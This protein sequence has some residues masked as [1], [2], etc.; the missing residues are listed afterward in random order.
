[1]ADVTLKCQ[2]PEPPLAIK[3]SHNLRKFLSLASIV[4]KVQRCPTAQQ[5]EDHKME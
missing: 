4:K 1:V 5:V 2:I 3:F